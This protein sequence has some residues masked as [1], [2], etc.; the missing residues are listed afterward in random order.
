MLQISSELCR[1]QEAAT[2]NKLAPA[3]LTGGTL[4][5]SNIGKRGGGG[6]KGVWS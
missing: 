4:T 1:L 3:D 6:R 2:A 5:I